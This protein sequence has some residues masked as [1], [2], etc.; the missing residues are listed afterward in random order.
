MKGDTGENLIGLL[1]RRLDTVA[2]RASSS[3]PCRHAPFINHG[4]VTERPPRQHL[5]LQGR[6]R[7]RGKESSKQLA[8]F[9]KKPAR[10]RRA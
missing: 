7:R 1:E 8:V 4:H 6:R 3:P 2:H 5:E 10:A 9:W